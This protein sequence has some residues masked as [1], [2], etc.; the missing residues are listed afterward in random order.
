MGMDFS[1]ANNSSRLKD[2]QKKSNE[3]SNK[4]VVID[5]PLDKIDKN[6]DNEKVFDMSEIEFLAKG[7]EDDGFFG[8]IEVYK[9]PDGR[10]EISSGHRRYEAMKLLKRN[11]I[12]C[13]VN[14]MPNSFERGKKL[15]ASN[16]RNRKLTP[17]Q[18]AKAISY[19]DEL[20]TQ[21][22]Q[23]VN[24]TKQASEFFGISYSMIYRYQSLLKLIPELQKIANEP[25]FPF[26]ALR[27]A[28]IL[29]EEGQK[30][31][32]NQITYLIELSK[33]ENDKKSEIEKDIPG[34]NL[35]RPK[36]EQMIE[37]IRENENYLTK[38]IIVTRPDTV[39][40]E[41]LRKQDIQPSAKEMSEY[42]METLDELEIETEDEEKPNEDIEYF[43]NDEKPRDT[44]NTNPL[45]EYLTKITEEKSNEDDSKLLSTVNELK[46]IIITNKISDSILN[47]CI[48]TLEQM[49]IVLKNQKKTRG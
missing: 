43:E 8:A 12:P 21:A 20:L 33:K 2:I 29:T 42:K 10:Y 3:T 4:I 19:Y 14:K 27:K 46:D 44:L 48:E 16:I 45:N 18:Y 36:I 31:L 41:E 9:K 6:E 24:L 32:Y 39:V 26:S 23:K 49:L 38:P 35:T 40:Y 7:I 25:S 28:T 1:K 15:L 11:D 30:E 34:Y 22:G 37:T 5:I 47:N 17:L 13:I